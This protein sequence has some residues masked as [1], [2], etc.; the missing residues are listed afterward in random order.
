MEGGKS[1]ESQV[2]IY[3][4]EKK[5][6]YIKGK[7]YGDAGLLYPKILVQ[8]SIVDILEDLR[9]HSRAYLLNKKVVQT[10]GS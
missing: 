2:K 10:S 3:C 5:I 4:D 7:I 6:Q 8:A 9:K 1:S